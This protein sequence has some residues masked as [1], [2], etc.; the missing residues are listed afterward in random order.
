MEKFFSR[1]LSL[2]HS[3]AESWHVDEK[4]NS[5]LTQK[6]FESSFQQENY[7]N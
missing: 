4:G 6:E 3:H 1:K 7:E 2:F 5:D